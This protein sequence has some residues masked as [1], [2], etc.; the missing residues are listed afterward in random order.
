MLLLESH[1]L[2]EE[3][4]DTIIKLYNQGY[5]LGII[6]NN[7]IRN[8]SLT[9]YKKFKALAWKYTGHDRCNLF[10]KNLVNSRMGQ[11][12]ED[13]IDAIL[14][15][16]MLYILRNKK[17][18]EIS[19]K[20]TFREFMQKGY[21]CYSASLND[22]IL[23][24]SLTFPDIRLKNCLEIRNHDSQDN[25]GELSVCAFYKG[26]IYSKSAIYEVLEFLKPL[27]YE[28]L[29]I[30][31]LQSA[32]YGIDYMVE[33]L[34]MTAS[35]VIKHLF[36]ISRKYLSDI[37]KDY[38]DKIIEL[39]PENKMAIRFQKILENKN[40]LQEIVQ[41]I[42][43]DKKYN[44][45]DGGILKDNLYE[46]IMELEVSFTFQLEDGMYIGIYPGGY[47]YYGMMNNGMKNG[48][49]NWFYFGQ[50]QASVMS[51][52]WD[53]DMPNGWAEIIIKSQT[54]MDY[55]KTDLKD[56]LF[57]GEVNM[58]VELT[59]EEIN[60]GTAFEFIFNANQGLIKRLG[61][62]H[63]NQEIIA[64]GRNDEEYIVCENLSSKIG[65]PPW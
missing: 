15:V 21:Q 14:D 45:L 54:S 35:D 44:L 8:N 5:Y 27:N 19:G 36:E 52:N 29:E 47:I 34:K 17:T 18:I 42:I 25:L 33:K 12:F 57:N 49:G 60:P 3:T 38:L 7:S 43:K 20:I 1:I 50:T 48:Q 9:N 41:T 55:F 61:Y 46:L 28:D 23:H 59:G 58:Y 39:I 24:S 63:S 16:P 64:Y 2:D 26:I 51:G 6:S 32:K 65:V 30:L 11:G 10:Y 56:G 31:G 40:E 53:N 13:Y 62:N 4:K 37:E 22:Y